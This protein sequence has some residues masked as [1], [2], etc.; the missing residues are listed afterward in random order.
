MKWVLVFIVFSLTPEDNVKQPRVEGYWE[1][2]NMYD[3][4][5][6]RESLAEEIGRNPNG[7]FPIDTQGICVQVNQGNK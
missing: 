4:F 7:H 2:S 5:M 1:F 6:A 3:C